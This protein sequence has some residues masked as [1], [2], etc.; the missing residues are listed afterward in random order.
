MK[1]L[2]CSIENYGCLQ[3]VSFDFSDGL[4]Q[5]LEPNG[6][7]KST[8]VSF[9]CAM[10]YGLDSSTRRSITEND[11][12]HYHP[13][14]E[15]PF[16]GSL[17]FEIDDRQYRVE[18]FF[19]RREKEDSFLLY[20]L[21]TM[22]LSSDYSSNLGIELFGIDKAG[23]LKSTCVPQGQLFS[24]VNESVSN[25]LARLFQE[26]TDQSQ[27][28]KAL[29]S[30]N[31]ALRFYVKTGKRG[32]IA[33]LEQELSSTKLLLQESR[34]S[35]QKL[36]SL[37]AQL[38]V[39]K[40]EQQQ[41]ETQLLSVREKLAYFTR[42]EVQSHY[43]TLQSRLDTAEKQLDSIEEFFHDQLPD[44]SDIQLYL[45]Q[46]ND[47]VQLENQYNQLD[48]A[49]SPFIGILPLPDSF[50]DSGFSLDTCSP[51]AIGDILLQY[52]NSM[53]LKKENQ[54][55]QTFLSEQMA[56]TQHKLQENELLL[57]Q[58]QETE[59]NLAAALASYTEEL[60]P[61]S[62]SQS[63]SSEA[64]PKSAFHT[65]SLGYFLLLTFIFSITGICIGLYWSVPSAILFTAGTV[66]LSARFLLR[67][68]KY[69]DIFPETDSSSESTNSETVPESY[70]SE[71]FSSTE[72]DSYL[73]L[74]REQMQAELQIQL[75]QNSI[76]Q[77]RQKLEQG[78]HRLE[79]LRQAF[80]QLNHE[81]EQ[82]KQ[83]FA[84][85]VLKRQTLRQRITNCTSELS[86]Y[87]SQYYDTATF[88]IS[89]DYEDALFELEQQIQTYK[90]LLSQFKEASEEIRV[91]LRDHSDFHVAAAV[92]TIKDSSQTPA[93]SPN[94]SLAEL[95]HTESFLQH[96][97]TEHI[98]LISQLEAEIT[99]LQ[100]KADEY[101]VLQEKEHRLQEHLD[102]CREHHRILS[103]TEYY[104]KKSHEL[105]ADNYI[106][107]I[108]KHFQ[109]YYDLFLPPDQT[110][111]DMHMTSDFRI[112]RF[113]Q[114]KLRET[115]WYSQGIQDITDLC[116][117]LSIIEDLFPRENPVLIF[118]DS[119]VNLDDI[120]LKQVSQVLQKLA[121]KWQILYL[122]CHTSR[123][124]SCID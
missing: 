100:L 93:F 103:L 82:S 97:I 84:G 12:K 44:E 60:L 49:L 92:T 106:Q 74:Q 79:I 10:L 22:Q 11:R 121:E 76:Q 21:K 101:P 83:C 30:I 72:K 28:D 59:Q 40:A 54:R 116:I 65:N 55:D 73:K 13:W 29:D 61:T 66:L 31:K 115:D 9:L 34:L 110:S 111:S 43:N 53:I 78:T 48:A 71:S 57:K 36:S 122:T 33:L 88:Q 67:G 39:L 95:Q 7:G 15:G 87:L 69:T 104:L 98:S 75:C 81:I 4:N 3:H 46:C 19:G 37:S 41:D 102:K 45:T 114:G 17:E 120:A 18:R 20:N 124:F 47:L 80:S 42:M 112:L 107:S 50:S 90:K 8:F 89:D 113:C 70:S 38:S 62:S 64:S 94:E 5:F 117:R 6:W 56:H 96:R 109:Y 16:G 86:S 52:N 85:F 123:D 119:F 1:F 14:Q 105:F 63:D 23:Y 35:N 58:H 27:Y 51:D 91:F 108:E 25:S 99:H 32:E 24:G 68:L 26:D 77:L 2:H 118:D